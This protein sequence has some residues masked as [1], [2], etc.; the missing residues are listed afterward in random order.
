MRLILLKKD[1]GIPQKLEDEIKK[2]L[3]SEST[4][5]TLGDNIDSLNVLGVGIGVSLTNKNKEDE[6]KKISQLEEFKENLKKDEK[7]SLCSNLTNHSL[8]EGKILICKG[9]K[10]IL[11]ENIKQKIINKLL[12]SS[13]GNI[14]SKQTSFPALL[15]S[16][17]YNT[18][19]NN[20]AYDQ[21][22][23]SSNNIFSNVANDKNYPISIFSN[24]GLSNINK[25]SY[26]ESNN[27]QDLN[28]ILKN[29]SSNIG[30]I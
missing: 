5:E 23:S 13:F 1:Q 6:E 26:L 3:D 10:A 18:I 9:C 7:I 20:T 8:K 4:L 27:F 21:I 15:Y 11:K 30:Y 16:N 2:L 29:I 28:L 24:N 25:T 19:S 17:M 22:N 12:D 14:E